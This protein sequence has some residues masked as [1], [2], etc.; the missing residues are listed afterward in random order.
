MRSNSLHAALRVALSGLGLARAGL[1]WYQ[2]TRHTFASLFV[3]KGGSLEALAAILG[4]SSTVVTR[5]GT[6]TS[7]RRTWPLWM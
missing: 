4:H 3:V 5:R 1:G 6:R 2:A 7:C